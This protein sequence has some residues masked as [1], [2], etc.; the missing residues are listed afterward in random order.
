MTTT[1]TSQARAPTPLDQELHTLRREAA[2]L[3]APTAVERN[4]MLAFDRHHRTGSLM[5]RLR[6]FSGGRV[7]DWFAP[8]AAVA[9]SLSMSLWLWLAPGASLVG[10]QSMHAAQSS[11][12]SGSRLADSFIALQPL[13]Q[14]ALEPN[15]RVIETQV[16][17]VM[18]SGLGIAIPP[19]TANESLRAELLVSASGQALAVRFAP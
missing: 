9:V 6:P 17:K 5:N 7:A 15:P 18:L 3:N 8:S 10:T 1:D 11:I 13:D 14:I 16:P 2:T 19:E 12:S 4:V